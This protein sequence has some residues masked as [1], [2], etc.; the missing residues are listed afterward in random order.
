[1]V[2]IQRAPVEVASLSW[3]NPLLTMFY[4]FQVVI[5]NFFHQQYA[6][7][8]SVELCELT[9]RGAAGFKDLNLNLASFRALLQ[10]HNGA[11]PYPVILRILGFFSSSFSWK[12]HHSWLLSSP[13]ITA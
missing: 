6:D 4:T 2:E 10:S 12:I 13:N 1:M 3:F 5:W 7:V 9:A 11:V 8:K